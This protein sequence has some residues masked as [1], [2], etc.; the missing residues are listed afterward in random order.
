MSNTRLGSK[1][2]HPKKL[3]FSLIKLILI[4]INKIYQ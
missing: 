2:K 1:L 3:A 4:L